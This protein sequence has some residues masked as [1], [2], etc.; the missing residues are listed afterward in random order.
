[1][2]NNNSS[3]KFPSSSS[4]ESIIE[5]LRKP[6]LHKF[7]KMKNVIYEDKHESNDDSS[8]NS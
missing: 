6:K 2:D 1:M 4:D 3:K 7:T 8:N 5:D